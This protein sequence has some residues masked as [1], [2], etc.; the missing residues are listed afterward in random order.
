MDPL[1]E[2]DGKLLE[3]WIS[4][5]LFNLLIVVIL[6]V[7]IVLSNYSGSFILIVKTPWTSEEQKKKNLQVSLY[8]NLHN[9]NYLFSTQL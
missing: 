3:M 7:L 9:K 5:I 8:N 4:L 1:K 2:E 6:S